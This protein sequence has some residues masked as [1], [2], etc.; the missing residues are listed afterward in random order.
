MASTTIS[1]D[2]QQWLHDNLARK[3]PEARLLE[4]MTQANFDADAV[5]AYIASLGGKTEQIP[6][7]RLPQPSTL[8]GDWQH[9]LAANVDQGVFERTLVDAAT[10]DIRAAWAKRSAHLQ[11]QSETQGYTYEPLNFPPGPSV[12]AGGRSVPVLMT[13]DRPRIVLFGNV[14]S[15]DECA[16]IIAMGR[17]HMAPSQTRDNATAELVVTAQRRSQGT[18]LKRGETTLVAQLE[19]R[20]A[21]LADWPEDRGEGLQILNYGTGGEYVPHFDFF[22]PEQ[23]SSQVALRRGGQRVATLIVYLNTVEE[24]GETFFPKLNLKIKAV[25]G[26]ALYFSYTNSKNEL[27]RMTLHGGSPVTR[28]E[29]WIMTKWMRQMAV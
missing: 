29:K 12:Q 9:W 7:D 16:A 27:D 1:L 26:N 17:P 24:G 11:S 5:R 22:P 28:G 2:W 21:D 20:L 10:R 19:Q 13:I 3:V 14:L 25:Q 23:P 4:V 18:F 15:P 8:Q 6:P